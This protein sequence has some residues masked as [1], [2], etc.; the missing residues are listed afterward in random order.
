MVSGLEGLLR[1]AQNLGCFSGGG[2]RPGEEK[3]KEER[4]QEG[5]TDTA[6]VV[7]RLFAGGP[8]VHAVRLNLINPII[9]VAHKSLS[10]A[11]GPKESAEVFA[12]AHAFFLRVGLWVCGWVVVMHGVGT[13]QDLLETRCECDSVLSAFIGAGLSSL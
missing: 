7:S 13:P 3:R 11:S 1:V 9:I 2:L 4:R 8:S 6:A 10:F 5:L 12:H